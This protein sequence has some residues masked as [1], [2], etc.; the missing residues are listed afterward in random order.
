M[1]MHTFTVFLCDSFFFS[2][3]FTFTCSTL[4]IKRLSYFCLVKINKYIISEILDSINIGYLQKQEQELGHT[5]Q[6][7]LL[8]HMN[9]LCCS[10]IYHLCTTVGDFAI[11]S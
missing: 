2:F 5:L 3:F 1:R 10:N 9:Y 8:Q 7:S 4:T 6:T 11:S